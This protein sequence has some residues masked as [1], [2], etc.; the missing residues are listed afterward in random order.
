M[1]FQVFAHTGLR[2]TAIAWTGREFL[3]VDNTTNRVWAAGPSGVRRRLF[4]TMPREVEETRCVISP[5]GHGFPAGQIYCNSP[6]NKIY[7]ISPDGKK[8]A[9]FAV[10][11]HSPRSDGALTFDPVGRFGYTLLAATG[12][13]GSAT[14]HGG[15]VFRIDSRGVVRRVGAY[16]N[17]GGADEIDIAPARFGSA[18][19]SA[20]LTVDAGHAGSLVAMDARG[21]ARTL[22][23]FPD[24]LNP[25]AILAPGRAPRAGAAKPGLYITDTTS[26]LVYRVAASA[27]HPYAGDVVVGSE[28]RG[29]FW[30]V[31]PSAGSFVAHRLSTSLA[32]KQYNLEGAAYIASAGRAD[33]RK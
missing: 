28:L 9:V 29:W 2:L 27:L 4:A 6:T 15:T 21:H 17:A 18:A 16:A 22:A 13:S 24:G 30:V 10:L 20:L 32:G 5:G 12:R 25:I 26:H 3:Y 8:I 7:R 23:R 11:P 31:Q 19:G 14:A 33:V 1:P